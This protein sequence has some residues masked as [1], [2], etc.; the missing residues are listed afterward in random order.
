MTVERLINCKISNKSI[1]QYPDTASKILTYSSIDL[2]HIDL[3]LQISRFFLARH[4]KSLPKRDDA[5]DD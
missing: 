4:F 1:N 5:E 2:V 3:T